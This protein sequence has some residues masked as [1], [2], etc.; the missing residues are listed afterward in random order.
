LFPIHNL[1][2]LAKENKKTDE[3]TDIAEQESENINEEKSTTKKDKRKL[4]HDKF[5]K[6]ENFFGNSHLISA[7]SLQ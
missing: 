7:L 6:S 1:F 2:E 5:L 3:T 4:R